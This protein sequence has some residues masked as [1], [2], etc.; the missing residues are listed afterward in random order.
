VQL[1]K[2]AD[3]LPSRK[4]SSEAV[5]VVP[6]QGFVV[7]TMVNAGW[8]HDFLTVECVVVTTV[9]KFLAYPR[10]DFNVQIGRNRDVTRIE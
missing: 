10:A 8:R 1:S 5:F 6:R 4:S 9:L 7:R 3:A 2:W